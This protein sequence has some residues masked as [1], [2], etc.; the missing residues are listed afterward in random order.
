M[1]KVLLVDDSLEM[2]NS[3]KQLLQIINGVEVVGEAEDIV[4][5]KKLVLDLKPDIIILDYQ[6]KTGTGIDVL[7]FIRNRKLDI[8]TI[9]LSNYTDKKYRDLALKNGAI[10]YL[11]KSLETEELIDSILSIVQSQQE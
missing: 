1:K 5:A 2:R 11:E 7:D 4:D 8:T 9:V 3:L 6:L 10:A